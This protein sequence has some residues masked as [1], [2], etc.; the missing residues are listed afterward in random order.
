MKVWHRQ[1]CEEGKIKMAL[2]KRP[3]VKERGLSHRLD[4]EVRERE[5]GRK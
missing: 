1:S 3:E 2:R 4:A 5:G